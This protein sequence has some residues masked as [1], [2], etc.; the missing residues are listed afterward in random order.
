MVSYQWKVYLHLADYSPADTDLVLTVDGELSV[1]SISAPCRLFPSRHSSSSSKWMVSYQWK[2]H[3]HPP[4]L[5]PADTHQVPPSW[6]WV[7][8]RKYICIHL[9][10]FPKQTIIKFLQVDGELSVENTSEPSRP[11]PSRHSSSSSKWMVSYQWKMHLHPPDLSQADFHQVPPSG[12]WVVN[13][14]YICTLQ[15]IPQ[16]TLF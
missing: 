16:Q 4:D 6:R 1:E 7:V 2:I 12:W 9:Q 11:F 8:N 14:K 10:T 5:S 13:G 3:L 15:T